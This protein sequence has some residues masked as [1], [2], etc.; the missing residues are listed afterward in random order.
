MKITNNNNNNNLTF[1]LFLK[2]ELKIRKFFGNV[3][4]SLFVCVCVVKLYL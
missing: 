2:D 4:N 1:N 3:N